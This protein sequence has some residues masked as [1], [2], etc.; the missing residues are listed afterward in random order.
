[1]DLNEDGF[2]PNTFKERA[3]VSNPPKFVRLFRFGHC[4]SQLAHRH[5]F[6]YLSRVINHIGSKFFAS[7]GH[8]KKTAPPLEAEH[9]DELMTLY[10]EDIN[11]LTDL[12]GAKSKIWI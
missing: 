4:V 3:N 11:L 6:F 12:V 9:Y 10:S 1:M 7:I 2:D 5:H 8:S